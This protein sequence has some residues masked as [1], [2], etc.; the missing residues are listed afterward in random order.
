MSKSNTEFSQ[1][2]QKVGKSSGLFQDIKIKTWGDEAT[3]PFE[4]DAVLDDQPL[5]LST[6]GY[7]VSQSLPVLTEVFLRPHDSW[8]AIQQPEVHLHPRAQA[9][10]GDV[11]FEMATKAHK[12]FLIETHSDFAIDRFRL[13]YRKAG[14]E[15]P[16]G[17]ILFFERRDKQNVVTALP[18]SD[19]GDL[20]AD[21]PANYREF[22]INEELTILSGDGT[23]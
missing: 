12:H 20:P 18:I 6:V 21:Q 5:N 13:N 7:G 3:G 8:F 16:D 9:A 14:A 1:F 17:Q 11:F 19:S 15:K 10:L 2:I 22:F 4:V 23:H